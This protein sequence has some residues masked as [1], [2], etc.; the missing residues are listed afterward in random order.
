MSCEKE[1]KT[2]RVMIRKQGTTE[3]KEITVAYDSKQICLQCN[4]EFWSPGLS[5]HCHIV[6][7][8]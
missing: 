4:K 1:H 8:D 6:K 2:M 7:G 5:D 3:Y